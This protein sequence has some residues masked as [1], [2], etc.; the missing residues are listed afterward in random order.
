MGGTDVDGSER[1]GG[2]VRLLALVLGV[3][4]LLT[5]VEI[6]AALYS[7]SLVLLADAGHYATDLLS[8][9]I[10]LLAATWASRPADAQH[11]FGHA[12]AA[13]LAAFVNAVLLWG[14]AAA[15]VYEAYLRLLSPQPVAGDWVVA[16][17]AVTLV[18]N[19]L[20]ALYLRRQQG[21]NLNLRAVSVHL[22]SDGLGSAAAIGAGLLVVL[23]GD[24]WADPVASLF[25]AGLIVVFAA[26]LTR[27]TVD[28]LIEGTPVHLDP[29]EVEASLL[30]LPLVRSVHDLHLW[31]LGAGSDSM[32][33]HV[34]LERPPSDDRVVH[35]IQ[36][37]ARE[38]FR[39]R[40]ATIQV[41]D[42]DCPC[43]VAPH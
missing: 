37:L 27:Q 38:R 5:V 1:A 9:G 22:L 21:S 2:G 26:R 23:R 12:R 42:P 43:G 31:T 18:A 39:I 4:A 16:I 14:V 30:G 41:E 13:V 32:S 6:G 24:E 19:L 25:V 3:G 8:I 35:E 34:V 36:R 10:A 20:L 28:I 7:R 40:H 11:S 15:L 29:A 33:V 17:G